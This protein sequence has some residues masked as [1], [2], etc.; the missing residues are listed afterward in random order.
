MHNPQSGANKLDKPCN[1]AFV[2]INKICMLC[3]MRSSACSED[4]QRSNLTASS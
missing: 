3:D 2:T 1:V 4:S